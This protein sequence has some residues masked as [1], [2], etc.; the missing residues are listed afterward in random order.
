MLSLL[1]ERIA[2]CERLLQQWTACQQLHYVIL[3]VCHLAG[4]CLTCEGGRG[5]VSQQYARQAALERQDLS[6]T[7]LAHNELESVNLVLFINMRYLQVSSIVQRF[8]ECLL[9]G[10]DYKDSCWEDWQ[11]NHPADLAAR[12]VQQGGAAGVGGAGRGNCFK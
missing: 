2:W 7:Y 11:N 10:D 5:V 3:V 4:F 8:Y 9:R 12:G 6:C 1:T